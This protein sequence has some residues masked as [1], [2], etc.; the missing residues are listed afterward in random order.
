MTLAVGQGTDF[1]SFDPECLE[2]GPAARELTRPACR[3]GYAVL[4]YIQYR[5]GSCQGLVA[6]QVGMSKGDEA[7]A[8]LQVDAKRLS[9]RQEALI[10]E[11][12]DASHARWAHFVMRWA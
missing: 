7:P 5:E 8:L 12:L 3:A 11:K 4:R 6:Q 2:S 1:D 10:G 9:D